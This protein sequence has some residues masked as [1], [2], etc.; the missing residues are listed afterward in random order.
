MRVAV[1]I[2]LCCVISGCRAASDNAAP[3]GAPSA[4]RNLVVITIDTLRADRVGAYGYAAGRTAAMDRLARD[5]V[6]FTHAY[7]TAPITLTSHASL[8]TGRYPAGQARGTTGCG[9]I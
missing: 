7:A 4:A 5:G 8:M 3:A 1:A 2:L 6:M 9:S